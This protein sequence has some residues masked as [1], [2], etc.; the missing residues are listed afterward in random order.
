LKIGPLIL[1]PGLAFCCMGLGIEESCLVIMDLVLWIHSE[2]DWTEKFG[3]T[4]IP[5]P[6]A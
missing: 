4:Y 3:V 6:I 5:G 1:V 2:Q